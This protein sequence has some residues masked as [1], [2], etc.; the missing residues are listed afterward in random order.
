MMTEGSVATNFGLARI[1][2]VDDDL[3]LV[4]ALRSALEHHGYVVRAVNR[5]TRVLEAAAQF[6]PSLIILDVMMPGMDGWEVLTRLRSNP[7]TANTPVIMLTAKDT[8]VS[9]IKGFSLGADDYVTK[10]FG[11]EELRWRIAAVLRR[12]ATTEPDDDG[13]TIPVLAGTSG[14][15]IVHARDVYYVQGIRNYTYVHTFD[16]RLLSRLSLGA[17][18]ALELDNLMRVHRSYVVNLSNVRGC[19]WAT[20]SSYE[21]RLA[22]LDGTEVPVSRSLISEVQQRLGIRPQGR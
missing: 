17:I 13:G 3:S 5:G 10:P 15:E 19:H 12:T 21:L 6:R 11:V 22:D 2:L 18:E 4:R 9:K 7:S 8:P 14:Y 16:A 1:L 20:R